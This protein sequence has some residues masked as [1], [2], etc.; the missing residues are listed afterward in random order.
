MTEFDLTRRDLLATAGVTTVLAASG[1][2]LATDSAVAYP[3]TMQM[4]QGSDFT[5]EADWRE[6]YNDTPLEDTRANATS[7]GAVISLG[8]L[9]P[10][11]SGTFSFRLGVVPESEDD[12]LSVEPRLSLNLT[13]TSENGLNDS[14]REIGDTAGDGGEL[15]E[16]LDVKLWYDQG[17]AD[18]EVFGGDNA[19]QDV[20]EGLVASGADGTL[21]EV[22]D[23]VTDVPLDR[24]GCLDPDETLTISF[25]WQLDSDVGNVV[26]TDSAQFDFEIT[27]RQC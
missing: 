14:E 21:T 17:L 16:N 10:G 18:Y 13:D 23:A 6:T 20:G 25:A 12:A 22:A 5:L 19:V 11:D 26:Q 1:L 8:N 24:N 7:N 3:N 2:T 4:Y 15:A 27:A 9:V